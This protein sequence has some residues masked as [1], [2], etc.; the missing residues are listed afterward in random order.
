ML[1]FEPSSTNPLTLLLAQVLD[2]EDAETHSLTVRA[3][4]TSSLFDDAM[5]RL[6]V[7]D[8]N[9]PSEIERIEKP[10]GTTLGSGESVTVREMAA[11]GAIVGRVVATDQDSGAW[12]RM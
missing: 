6:I 7:E 10:D 8:K 2:H 4:D 1:S 3:I 5:I 12:G 11:G 9:E